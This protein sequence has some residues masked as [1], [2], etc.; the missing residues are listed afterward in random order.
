ML[1]YCQK[2]FVLAN[3]KENHM[4]PIDYEKWFRELFVTGVLT[5]SPFMREFFPKMQSSRGQHEI[6]EKDCW[7]SMSEIVYC[8]QQVEKIENKKPAVMAV[9]AL[10]AVIVPISLALI[11]YYFSVPFLCV[12]VSPVIVLFLFLALLFYEGAEFQQKIA[13]QER[14]AAAHRKNLRDFHDRL[15]ESGDMFSLDLHVLLAIPRSD[16][17]VRRADEAVLARLTGILYLQAKLRTME[18]L[19]LANHDTHVLRLE[20]ARKREIVQEY[21]YRFELAGLT[22]RPWKAC[23]DMAMATSATAKTPPPVQKTA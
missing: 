7:E 4:A 19:A 3:T 6:T 13:R 23:W 16:H 1:E 12:I 2:L 5:A 17:L 20:I 9:I 11:L 8:R 18:E 22:K 10:T 15:I 21:F 14:R